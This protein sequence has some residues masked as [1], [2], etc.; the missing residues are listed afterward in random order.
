MREAEGIVGA[1]EI[2]ETDCPY[3][4]RPLFHSGTAHH[5]VVEAMLAGGWVVTRKLLPAPS[6]RG[7]AVR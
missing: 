7:E 6:R 5:D 4:P 1:A 2:T 3:S